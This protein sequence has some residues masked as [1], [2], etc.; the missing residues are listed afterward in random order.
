MSIRSSTSSARSSFNFPMVT[1]QEF[2]GACRERGLGFF[3]G[4]PCSYLKPLI[5]G[6]LNDAALGFRD[7]VN[8]GDAVALAA[9]AYLA[10]GRPGVVMFQNSGLGNAVNALTSLNW[11]FR[12]PALLIVTHRGEPGGPADEPQ[13]ELMGAVTTALLETM[14]VPWAA[15]PADAA[16][17]GPALER[18]QR[19][20]AEQSL[21]FAFV[22]PHGAVEETPLTTK[23]PTA[24][25]GAREFAF[26]E[27]LP[28]ATDARATR[29][30]ALGAL[31]AAKRPDD[32]VI[33]TTGFMGRELY[34]LGD[35]VNQLYLVGAMGG[36][37]AVGL[38]LAL[39]R[40]ERRVIVADGDGAVLM[41]M[42]NLAMVGAHAPRNLLHLVLDNEAH[43]STGAQATLSR[44]V[45]FG[46]IAQACGYTRAVGT[47]SLEVLAA[48]LAV[49]SVQSGP[50]LVH[51]RT[52]TG[53][54]A[55]LGR[56][57]IS[58]CEAK[59][60]LMQFLGHP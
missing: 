19:H 43:D 34:T 54:L 8:E 9:G 28:L 12:I 56:P 37:S 1:A 29:A 10:T 59:L 20:F 41:R 35:A 23:R 15:F 45:A 49:H 58:P 57:K 22:M 44:G 27:N 55:K 4:T 31:L 13:H 52:R 24:A 40:P 38:G 30:E 33:A 36:A 47:D 2:L 32:V 6:A 48:E 14:R 17:I 60:R 18:A 7:A 16:G 51:F 3:T 11:P 21:P 42:G 53:T 5:N 39:L 46:A 25:L 50:T 26:A